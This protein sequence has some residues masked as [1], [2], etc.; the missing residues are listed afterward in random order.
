VAQYEL[1]T[2]VR[3]TF[4]FKDF[5]GS[6]VDPTNPQVSIYDPSGQAV[7]TDAAMVQSATGVWYYDWQSPETGLE[8]VYVAKATGTI[9]SLPV[10]K[11]VRIHMVGIVPD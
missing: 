6:N 11:K 2:T 4:T 8:G 7:V 1:G 10:Q 3:I 9:S 5:Q